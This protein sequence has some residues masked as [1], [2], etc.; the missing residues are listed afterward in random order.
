M[1]TATVRERKKALVD[2]VSTRAN[3]SSP[4]LG[5]A[6]SPTWLRLRLSRQ[7]AHLSRGEVKSMP[8]GKK[9]ASK[10]SKELSSK[11]STKDEK[12]VA[13]SDLAQRKGAKKGK[14]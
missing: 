5:L 1:P 11:S 13:A 6:L 9:P 14:K 12:T 3:P 8:T 4:M 10:A 7:R 2:P